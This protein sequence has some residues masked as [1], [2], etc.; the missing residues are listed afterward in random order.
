MCCVCLFKIGRFKICAWWWLEQNNALHARPPF[1]WSMCVCVY[2]L[3]LLLLYVDSYIY[4]L[5]IYFIICTR[6][7]DALSKKYFHDIP[8]PLVRSQNGGLVRLISTWNKN[9][10]AVASLST[11]TED[12][13][14][15]E[16]QFCLFV[17]NDNWIKIL[18]LNVTE[19]WFVCVTRMSNAKQI[20][21]ISFCH[22][23]KR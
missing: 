10:M 17:L 15:T 18:K 16:N 12:R 14:H 5:Y 6:I 22:K 13:A 19:Y 20:E 3:L 21:E 4:I 23:K 9:M 2:V 8:A 7:K 1:Q 11:P